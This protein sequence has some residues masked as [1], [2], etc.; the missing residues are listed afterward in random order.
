MS[1][2]G[3]GREPVLYQ[4]LTRGADGQ[5]RFML[6][7]LSSVDWDMAMQRIL[8]GPAAGFPGVATL[9]WRNIPNTH[10]NQQSDEL[11]VRDDTGRPIPWN[12]VELPWAA[13][14]SRVETTSRGETL[15]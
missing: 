12:D 11:D 14:R 1:T 10:A 6:V 5:P 15:H 7:C 4:I 13:P 8:R 2:E 3:T 9:H